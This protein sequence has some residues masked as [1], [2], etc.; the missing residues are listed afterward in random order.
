MHAGCLKGM[1]GAC[2][3]LCGR[4]VLHGMVRLMG[5]AAGNAVNVLVIRHVP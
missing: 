3:A 5:D 4:L 2:A 1:R